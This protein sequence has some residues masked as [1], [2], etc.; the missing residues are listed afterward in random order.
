M[1]EKKVY[2]NYNIELCGIRL[3]YLRTD[4]VSHGTHVS[5]MTMTKYMSK[6]KNHY[7]VYGPIGNCGMH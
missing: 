1:F 3:L 2:G 7:M 4:Q 5:L 6:W